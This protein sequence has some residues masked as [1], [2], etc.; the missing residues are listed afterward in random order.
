MDWETI[1]QFIRAHSQAIDFAIAIIAMMNAIAAIQLAR[2]ASAR[3]SAM[4]AR[5]SERH[6]LALA[7]SAVL[8]QSS[9]ARRLGEPGMPCA[10]DATSLSTTSMPLASSSAS[11]EGVMPDESPKPQSVAGA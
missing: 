1:R 4:E 3:L 6:R 11:S 8:S 5:S 7:I 10:P 2:R 9:T